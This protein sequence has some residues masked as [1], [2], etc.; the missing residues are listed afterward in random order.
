MKSVKKIVWIVWDFWFFEKNKF[1][2]EDLDILVLQVK[3]E[4]DLE[5][6]DWLFFWTSSFFQL[7]NY[8]WES[9]F[10]VLLIK[11]EN[12][13]PVLSFWQSVNLFLNKIWNQW[14]WSLNKSSFRVKEYFWEADLNFLDSKKMKIKIFK[15]FNYKEKKEKNIKNIFWNFLQKNS[16]LVKKFWE[17]YFTNGWSSTVFIYKKTLFWI[18]SPEFYWDRR[19]F[20]YF[21]NDFI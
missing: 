12:N 6:C 18:F 9:F 8:F 2:F 7:K 13:F 20:E 4:D 17:V 1:F 11:I 21:I 5:K 14:K 15:N 3:D 16:N 10:N 19:I